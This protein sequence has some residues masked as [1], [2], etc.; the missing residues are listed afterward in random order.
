MHLLLLLASLAPGRYVGTAPDGRVDLELRVDGTAVFGGA[1]YAWR[2]E[3]NTLHLGDLRLRIEGE[4]L[5]GPPFG[6]VC[7][8]PAPLPPIVEPRQ[9]PRP[10]VW[11]GA[12]SHTASGG[13]LVLVLAPAGADEMRQPEGVP[14]GRW[15]GDA[16]GFTLTPAGG[17]ALR[18]RARRE[19]DELFVSG[20]DLPSEVRFH[21]STEDRYTPPPSAATP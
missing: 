3:G 18:Y 2:I 15:R 20:G 16:A 1:P 10:E 4:C 21:R 9:P 19:G 5:R 11:R 17:Q 7:L 6:E 14:G 13:T 8:R 12:W